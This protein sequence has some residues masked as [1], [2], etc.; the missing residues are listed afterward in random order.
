MIFVVP[1]NRGP[2]RCTHKENNNRCKETTRN[3]HIPAE[4]ASELPKGSVAEVSRF[5]SEKAWGKAICD[6]HVTN[7][8][9][10]G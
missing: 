8:M 2:F 7:E 3:L 10:E 4:Q 6:A 9:R 1:Y 5:I